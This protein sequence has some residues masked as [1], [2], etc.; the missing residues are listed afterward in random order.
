[1]WNGLVNGRRTNRDPP[2][3]VTLGRFVLPRVRRAPE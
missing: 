2:T 1:M 3:N